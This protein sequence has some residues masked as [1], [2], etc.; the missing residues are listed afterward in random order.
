MKTAHR[1][2]IPVLALGRGLAE[3][4]FVLTVK[5][6]LTG[7]DSPLLLAAIPV[8]VL[9]RFVFQDR[10]AV[11]EAAALRDGV[12]TWRRRVLDTLRHRAVPAWRP[13]TRRALARTLEEDIPVAAEGALA[14]RRLLGA[15][16]EG[17]VLLPLLFVFAWEAALVGVGA[18]AILWPVLRRR[19]RRMKDHERAGAAGRERARHA[20]EDFS[21]ALEVLPGT[22]LSEALDRLDR[23]LDDAHAPTW[24][25][26]R[27][28]ARYPA[29][30]E[31]SLFFVLCVILFTGALTLSGLESVLLFAMLLLLTYRPLREAARQYPVA[32]AGA[33]AVQDLRALVAEW[34]THAPRTAP[35][36][37]P[38]PQ[39]CGVRDLTFGYEPHTPVLRRVTLEFATDAVTGLTGPN[40]AGK[41]TLLR[42]LAGAETPQSGTVL[43]PAAAHAPRAGGTAPRGIAIMSQRAWPGHDWPAWADAF[44]AGD[45][46]GWRRLD[47]LLGVERLREKSFHPESLSGGERQRM[48]LART[49]TSDAAY[50]LLD[51]PTTSMP[52]DQRERVLRGALAFWKTRLPEPRGALVVSH[53]PFLETVCDA[54]VTL[55][56]QHGAAPSRPLNPPDVLP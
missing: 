55:G 37:H 3:A 52:A 28:Q 11:L 48:A 13:G 30:L 38:H 39:R 8:L 31:T 1:L 7:H 2:G 34:N 56:P 36:P 54:L 40:G 50:L 47:T 18:A 16:L 10:G 49:L 5:A 43:W 25:W 51:E 32:A 46:A 22:G 4:G 9:L 19:N 21:H 45:P 6:G 42:L 24:R 23:A 29:L 17:A 14:R 12:A 33:R 26:R 27:A 44:R 53:E 35:A 15:I 20:R 41:T